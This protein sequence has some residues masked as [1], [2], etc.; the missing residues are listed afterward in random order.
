[1]PADGLPAV[2]ADPER[3]GQVLA[4]LVHN[5]VKFTPAGGTITL[6]AER[7]PAGIRFAVRDSGA[8]IA[9]D[10]LDRVFERFY[11]G[12]RSRTGGGTGLGLS[13]ARHVVEAHGG[14]I[15]AESEGP[16][17]GSTFSFTLPSVT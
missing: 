10:D 4:N 14:T 17:R 5:A 6:G 11:K 7:D 8:G 16:G 2:L 1:M 12:E 3:V 15:R 9:R 13:I